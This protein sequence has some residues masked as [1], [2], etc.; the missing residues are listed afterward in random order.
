MYKSNLH[1]I[2]EPCFCIYFAVEISYSFGVQ[3]LVV[4]YTWDW[5][6][7][8]MNS[9]V[10]IIYL[11]RYIILTRGEHDDVIKWKHFPRYWPF[12]GGTTGDR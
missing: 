8:T 2:P 10:D 1:N 4:W 12:V 7:Y 11:I 3:H 6:F 5:N 9:D